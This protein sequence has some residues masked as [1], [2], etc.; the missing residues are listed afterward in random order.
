[1]KQA[2]IRTE[3]QTPACHG[4]GYQGQSLEELCSRLKKA[5][6][7]LVIDVRE[8]AWSH[9]PDF[10]KGKLEGGLKQVGIRYEHFPLA[11]NPY[12]PQN[13]EAPDFHACAIKYGAY[14]ASKPA[15]VTA[16]YHLLLDNRVGFFCYEA[17][18]DQC[19]RS[20]LVNT[21][22]KMAGAVKYENL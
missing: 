21:I 12:R 6:V 2:N 15:L 19:H 11:G 10:R 5:K 4:I 1:V 14:M 17:D 7:D 3:S 20:V 13:G 16:L 9:R 22:K 8:R 18:S